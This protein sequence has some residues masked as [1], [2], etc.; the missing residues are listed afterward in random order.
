M[1]IINI[2]CCPVATQKPLS[3]VTPTPTITQTNTPTPTITPTNTL[4]PTPTTSRVIVNI[5]GSL[6]IPSYWT[7]SNVDYLFDYNRF[8]VDLNSC[9][10]G[11]ISQTITTMP[12]QNYVIYF[13]LTGNCGVRI[14]NTV[15][16]K[17]MKLTLTGTSIVFDKTYTYTCP[18]YGFQVSAETF[19]WTTISDTFT[20]NSDSTILKFQSI[21]PD[22]CFGPMVSNIR[23]YLI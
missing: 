7:F 11:Y 16:N 20:A 13:D 4:T 8:Y 2:N 17:V 14:D 9:T 23:C 12:G 1:S 3:S 10:I 15:A 21:S 22:G 18:S 19:G 6:S 5:V